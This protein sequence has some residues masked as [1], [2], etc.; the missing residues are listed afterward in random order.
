LRIPHTATFATPGSDISCGRI[1]YRTIVACSMRSRESDRT[2]IFMTRLVAD[3]GCS[4]T[5][6]VAQLGKVGVMTWIRSETSRRASMT[7]V[8]LAKISSMEDCC[9]IDFERRESRPRIP[10]RPCSKGTVMSS[11]TS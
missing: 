9:G 5:G 8:P 1:L 6:G 2:P 3:S 4:T 7:S 10:V 11:S